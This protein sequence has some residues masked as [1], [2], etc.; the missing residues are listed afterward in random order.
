M[1]AIGSDKKEKPL[2]FEIALI[3]KRF[4]SVKVHDPDVALRLHKIPGLHGSGREPGVFYFFPD[5]E[6]E[7]PKEAALQYLFRMA[8][9]AG[10]SLEKFRESEEQ[11]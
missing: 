11:R 6:G 2:P 1:N 4:A 3:G 8:K 7:D 9:S 10:I 5:T